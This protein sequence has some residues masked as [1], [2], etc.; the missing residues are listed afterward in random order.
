MMSSPTVTRPHAGRRAAVL[1]SALVSA[2]LV[3][4]G[5]SVYDAPLPGGPSTGHNPMTIKVMFRDV[6]DLVP[7]S[8]VK[9]NDVTVG[10][11]K[12]VELKGYLAQVT[13]EVPGDID[14]PDN[15]RA[16]IRQTSLLGEKFVQLE[17]PSQ[18]GTGKLSNGDT[19]GLDRTGRNPEVEE[20]FG[21]LSLLLNGGGV[22]QLKTIVSELNNTFDGRESEVRSVL[23]QI[24]SFMGQ[25]DRNKESIVAALENT[26]RLAS[27]L[28]KQDTT[29]KSALDNV[30]ATLQS[31]NRQRDDLV[32]L[33]QALNRLS[34]V[35]VRVI[36]AS[37]ESTINSLRSLAPVLDGFA[38]AGENMPKSF[39]VFLT[40]P[41]VDEAIGRDP[42]VARNLHMGDFT[43]LSVNLDVDVLQLPSPSLPGLPG[44]ECDAISVVT[45]RANAAAGQ[46]VDAAPLPNPPYT[47][48]L[49]NAI[50]EKIA[51]RL[52]NE[53]KDQCKA[54][55]VANLI[56]AGT[57]I[58]GT[59]LR[60][61]RFSGL[62]EQLPG[63][64]GDVI[65]GVTEGLGGVVGGV[66]GGAGAGAGLLPRA[67]PGKAFQAPEPLDPFDLAARGLD[68][69]IGTML[70]QG[71]AVG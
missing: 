21:A 32:K 59:V 35:G 15:A 58:L 10:K 48:A 31:V 17:P 66:T 46:I 27:E 47:P 68:P 34:G 55:S 39:Q 69:G 40:Y 14:L 11:V 37:K 25:L 44:P 3:L 18:P 19:I 53:F 36:Q 33:L 9:V 65:D 16:Q 6:L 41:F 8:T 62:L 43:N 61:P 52:V 4:S 51:T 7:Q 1:L 28:K 22:G 50:R 57:D 42:Q 64:V 13:V 49:K 60:L 56:T 67:E 2:L 5:C 63:G 24:R 71:V 12:K 26:N 45:D 38:K 30:P 23:D 70:F 29:I 20:V 54:P